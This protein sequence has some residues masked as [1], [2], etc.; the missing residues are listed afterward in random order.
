MIC[1]L[2]ECS[3]AWSSSHYNPISASSS[4]TRL[5]LAFAFTLALTLTLALVFTS[6]TAYQLLLRRLHQRSS[7]WKWTHASRSPLFFMIV[8][9][10][11]EAAATICFSIESLILLDNCYHISQSANRGD[12][13]AT[14]LLMSGFP[15]LLRD[16]G[17][18]CDSS[19]THSSCLRPSTRYLCFSFILCCSLCHL[20]VCW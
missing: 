12:A 15:D 3:R 20:V 2:I 10:P 4:Q 9:F 17:S 13:D 7:K 8:N 11:D 6:T 5:S 18:N 1:Y 19:F 16:L 14:Y